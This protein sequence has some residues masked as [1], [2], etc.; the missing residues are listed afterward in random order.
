MA[1]F[2]SLPDFPHLS[3]VF[4]RFPKGAM[5]LMAFHDE[6]LRGESD[7]SAAERE[8]IAAYTSGLNACDFCHGSHT[9]IAEIHGIDPAIFE[10]LVDAP[11]RAGLED[12]WLP[13]LAYVRK[14]TLTPAILT[15]ADAAS[16][17]DAGWSEDALYDAIVVCATFNLM[18]RIVEGCGVVATAEGRAASRERHEAVKD[19][20][21][22]YSDF[23]RMMGIGDS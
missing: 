9:L 23:G 15:E 22:P 18:N 5:P 7:L 16:V 10:K 8:M 6:V 21:T 12:K 19:S 13:L 2:P 20:A 3:D 4:K 14:L 17:Y 1:Q 11:D